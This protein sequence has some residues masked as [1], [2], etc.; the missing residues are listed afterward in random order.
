METVGDLFGWRLVARLLHSVQLSNNL[1]LLGGTHRG[2]II[3]TV[4]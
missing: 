2:Q 4:L 3:S 1:A